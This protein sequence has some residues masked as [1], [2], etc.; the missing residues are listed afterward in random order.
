MKPHPT[1]GV[2]IIAGGA[3][4][5]LATAVPD[6]PKAL[7]PLG[8][9]TLLDHQLRQ[10][11]ALRP[12]QLC[13]LACAAH[14]GAQIAAAVGPRAVVL[15]ENTPLGTAGGLGLL[16]T[17]PEAWL[18]LNVDHVSDVQLDAFVA[19]ARPPC[20][21]LVVEKS[22]TIDE[23]VVQLAKD[24]RMVSWQE[25]P[26]LSVTVTTGLYLFEATALRARCTGQRLD[27]PA[28]VESFV[29]EGVWTVRHTGAWID[30]GTPERLA[31]AAALVSTPRRTAD[32][33][34]D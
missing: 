22:V 3:G 32:P 24:G 8:S 9:T 21:A 30:A 11:A 13:V 31:S 33:A 1:L 7:A 16:P 10:A 25:R 19:A 27:M 29:S 18:T 15:M 4:R 23:G 20:T 34:E 28:L 2:V 17:G 6:R 26:S 14:A 12:S 5:R